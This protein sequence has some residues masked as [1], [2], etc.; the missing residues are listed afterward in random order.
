SRAI[1]DRS[2]NLPKVEA[3][4]KDFFDVA[5]RL[6]AGGARAGYPSLV[7]AL[8]DR[9]EKKCGCEEP[10]FSAAADPLWQICQTLFQE[11]YLGDD[12][13]KVKHGEKLSKL[14]K[15]GLVRFETPIVPLGRLIDV[16]SMLREANIT[17]GIGT[18]RPR[19]EII[20]PLANWGL[21][22]FLSSSRI[23]TNREIAEA[24]RHLEKTG[25]KKSLAK[26]H[27]YVFLKALYPKKPPAE[28]LGMPLPLPDGERVLVVGDTVA[29]IAAAK[30]MGAQS[31]AVL[32]SVKNLE[33]AASIKDMEPDYILSD[34]TA[35]KNLF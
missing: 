15:D 35:L 29:D 16:L 20:T 17:L 2:P 5:D 26:P 34:V 13:F 9:A 32:S 33:R 28:I 6:R 25:S 14:A 7:A 8:N 22:N 31:A 3:L 23:S 21:L 1:S 12:L 10:V 18:G 27:P 30:A 19:V 11:W 4:G 24:E